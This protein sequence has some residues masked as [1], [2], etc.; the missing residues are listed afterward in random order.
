M[1]LQLVD[2][3]PPIGRERD[4]AS[5][6]RLW[7][8]RRKSEPWR[9]DIGGCAEWNEPDTHGAYVAQADASGHGHPGRLGGDD[10][11]LPVVTGTWVVAP[12]GSVRSAEARGVDELKWA[13]F[14]KARQIEGG[15]GGRGRPVLGDGG[16]RG[17]F[18]IG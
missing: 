13:S 7:I 4:H 15:P 9:K 3:R 12:L 16:R 17:R 8:S 2:G 5:S 11:H 18:I 14:S 1:A 10:A 6:S